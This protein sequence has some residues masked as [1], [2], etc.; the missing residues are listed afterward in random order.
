ML[1]QGVFKKLRHLKGNPLAKEDQKQPLSPNTPMDRSAHRG[2][3][4]IV[5]NQI[6]TYGI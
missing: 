5:C 4:P 3:L 2:C 6:I 1:S